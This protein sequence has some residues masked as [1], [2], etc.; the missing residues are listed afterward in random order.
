MMVTGRLSNYVLETGCDSTGL[1][2]WVYMT[3]G[4]D[5]KK[6]HVIV[7]YRPCAK[8][9]LRRRVKSSLGSSVC[10]QE[11]RYFCRRGEFRDPRN[12]FDVDLL[13]LIRK[14]RQNDEEVLMMGDFNKDIYRAHLFGCLGADDIMMTE[15][16]HQ[17]FNKHAPFSHNSGKKP[18]MGVFATP[19]IDCTAAFIAAHD[20]G[21]GDHCLHVFDFS[22]SAL[23][24]VEYV[25]GKRPAGRKL[26]CECV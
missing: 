8:S 18:I 17:L 7:V 14:W 10:E 11:E 15:Q 16:F 21:V 3:L 6:T 2:R 24:G 22:A 23:L 26:R 25:D 12:M 13:A 4:S 5:Y 9:Y 20:A 19:G 1:G